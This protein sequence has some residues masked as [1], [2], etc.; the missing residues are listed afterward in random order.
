MLRQTEKGVQGE[1]GR[2]QGMAMR[3]ASMYLLSAGWRWRWRYGGPHGLRSQEYMAG[4]G[5]EAFL[6][7][8]DT[9]YCNASRRKTG[10]A[11]KRLSNPRYTPELSPPP[12]SPP[13]PPA[14]PGRHC[15][16]G[17]TGQEW[18]GVFLPK[19]GKQGALAGH[20]GQRRE[21]GADEL[22]GRRQIPSL[23]TGP[24]KA[25]FLVRAVGAVR[26]GSYCNNPDCYY[27]DR[28]D[29]WSVWPSPSCTMALWRRSRL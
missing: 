19:P 12:P 9:I 16:A 8:L 5:G 17:R 28:C 4:I 26:R 15:K 25:T 3:A 6:G 14:H 2:S 7:R 20:L 21:D 23:P 22:G 13:P 10:E 18:G 1:L 29:C 24:A 27:C 11:V